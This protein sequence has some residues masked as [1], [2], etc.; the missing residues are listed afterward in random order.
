[1]GSPMAGCLAR[2]GFAVTAYDIDPARA[3][4]LAGDGVAPA[5]SIAEAAAG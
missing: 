1:M 5:T 2:A 4:A 3:Q